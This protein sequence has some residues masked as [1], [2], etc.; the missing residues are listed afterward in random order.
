MYQLFPLE[1][2]LMS[3]VWRGDTGL[4]SCLYSI[5]TLPFQ[6]TRPALLFYN[7]HILMPLKDMW[8]L[9]FK[10][11]IQKEIRSVHYLP[12]SSKTLAL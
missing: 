11:E 8:E 10:P 2:K 9:E 3:S 5:V 4:F 7:L 1:R 6:A 12:L